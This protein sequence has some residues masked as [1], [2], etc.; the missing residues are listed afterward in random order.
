MRF[1]LAFKGLNL[2]LRHR[3]YSFSY[4]ADTSLYE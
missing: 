3:K 1:I 4:M 2:R